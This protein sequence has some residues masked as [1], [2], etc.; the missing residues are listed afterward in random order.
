M[1]ATAFG[2]ALAA[3]CLALLALTLWRGWSDVDRGQVWRKEANYLERQ[4]TFGYQ[5]VGR[6][7][8]RQWPALVTD[9][10]DGVDGVAFIGLDGRRR[11]YRGFHGMQL[12]VVTFRP[13]LDQG[14]PFIVVL[15]RVAA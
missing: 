4:R 8:K 3:L 12:K 13:L 2:R 6:F 14:R 10:I 5:V 1:P 7:G 15:R 9:R 11:E